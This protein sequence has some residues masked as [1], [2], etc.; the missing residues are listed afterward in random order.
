MRLPEATH[1]VR[2]PGYDHLHVD[3]QPAIGING[4]MPEQRLWHLFYLERARRV[5]WKTMLSDHPDAPALMKIDLETFQS[6][7]TDR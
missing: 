6:L 1:F 4:I 7:P 5:I 2:L 3:D